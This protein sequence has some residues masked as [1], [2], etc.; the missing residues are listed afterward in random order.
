MYSYSFKKIGL[1][2]RDLLTYKGFDLQ[3][4]NETTTHPRGYMEPVISVGKEKEIREVNSQFLVVPCMSVYN[5]I[6]GR[7]IA[8]TL[9]I[10][11]SLVHL[12][13]EYHNLQGESTAISADVEEG[14]IIYKSFQKYHG[15]DIDMEMNV[16]SLTRKLNRM[17]IHPP[18]SG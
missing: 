13:L 16:T 4:F 6:L 5:C 15:E 8:S 1:D 11:A 17:D 10:V 18:R 14:K 2:Q 9:D 12:K 3:E 7:P